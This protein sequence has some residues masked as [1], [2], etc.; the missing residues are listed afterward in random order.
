MSSAES[1]SLSFFF[2]IF[3]VG[4]T[5]DRLVPIAVTCHDIT[6]FDHTDKPHRAWQVAGGLLADSPGFNQPSLERLTLG[7][8]PACFPETQDKSEE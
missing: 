1:A 5:V 8:L 4:V 7:N 6:N 3:N 2:N